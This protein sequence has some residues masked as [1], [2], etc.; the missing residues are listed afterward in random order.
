MPQ[1]K[2]ACRGLC[3]YRMRQYCMSHL[4]S[5]D[6]SELVNICHSVQHPSKHEHFPIL[7]EGKYHQIL[8]HMVFADFL[9]RCEKMQ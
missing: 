8:S 9:Y 2:T 6:D 5:Q 7:R 4:V 3:T 1:S